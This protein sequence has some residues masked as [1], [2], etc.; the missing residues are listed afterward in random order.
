MTGTLSYCTSWGQEG[1]LQ[2]TC[3]SDRFDPKITQKTVKHP[4]KGHGLGLF[5]LAG[6]GGLDFLKKAEMM[7][8]LRYLRVLEDQAGTVHEDSQDLLLSASWHALPQGKDC[9]QEVW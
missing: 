8:S 5:Y 9:D 6:W 7:N 4:E 1:P 3:G 2:A